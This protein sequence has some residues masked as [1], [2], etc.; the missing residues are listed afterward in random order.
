MDI[1]FRQN[2][3]WGIDIFSTFWVKYLIIRKSGDYFFGNW[4]H[5]V[6]ILQILQNNLLFS[7]IGPS[8]LV[9][10]PAISG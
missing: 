5:K 8:A 1:R 2:I 6:A 7:E 10:P 9:I 4:Q 3:S